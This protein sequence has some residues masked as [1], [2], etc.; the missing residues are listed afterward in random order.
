MRDD[1][2]PV[3]RLDVAA[4]RI[5]TDQSESDGTMAW[6]ATSVVVV[7]AGAGG[8]SGLGYS[9]AHPAAGE[10][11]ATVLS[12]AVVGRDAFATPGA[13]QAMAVTVRNIGR[14]GIAS[15]AIAAT[16]MALWD[17]KARLLGLSLADLLGRAREGIAVYGS[18]GFTSY[19][20]PRLREQLGAWAA[21]GM[22]FVKM[23][24]GREPERDPAR[25][26]A[27][28]EAIGPDVELFVDANGAFDRPGALAMASALEGLGVT[29][30]EEP[31]SSDD[32]AGLALVREKAPP[33]MAVAAGEYGY[34][35][36]YFGR[37]LG[38]GAVDCLQADAT[39]CGG[40]TAFLG[41]AGLCEAHCL[42]LSAHTAPSVHAHLCCALPVARH[43]EYFHDHARV[44]RML[45]DGVLEPRDGVLSP[46]RSRPGLGIALKGADAARYAL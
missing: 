20:L 38:A 36:P 22:R 19:D 24:I 32:L 23:K 17:L 41:V 42:P 21:A 16:D 3:E 40:P 39:R 28:R 10:V 9:Y 46:D 34:D 1:G 31:V 30:F 14:P 43:V 2:P 8:L 12:E 37:M 11:V 15:S 7:H 29:W 4:Y 25:V 35:L 27:A 45:F 18:G 26:A 44:E 5:P 33:G 6:D 13:W